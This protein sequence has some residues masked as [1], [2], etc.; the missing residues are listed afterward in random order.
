M[1]RPLP[2]RA[3]HSKLEKSIFLRTEP[4]ERERERKKERETERERN[5]KKKNKQ[6]PKKLCKLCGLVFVISYSDV[7]KAKFSSEKSKQKEKGEEKRRK[8]RWNWVKRKKENTSI[9]GE[10]GTC[11]STRWIWHQTSLPD[12]PTPHSIR[13]KRERQGGAMLP[14]FH[15]IK[16]IRIYLVKRC[17]VTSNLTLLPSFLPPSYSS[18]SFF[19]LSHLHSSH[20]NEFNWETLLIRWKYWA[21]TDRFTNQT[22]VRKDQSLD[23]THRYR[24][25]NV[26]IQ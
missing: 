6:W 14:E 24:L 18:P 20:I 8:I 1:L 16:A 5:R 25:T 12:I 2:F 4:R 3:G 22:W 13:N 26:Y 11:H 10:Y 21:I 17:R 23:L 7:K 9:K 19:S 15:L